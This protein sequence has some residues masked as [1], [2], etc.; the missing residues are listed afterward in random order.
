MSAP[1]RYGGFSQSRTEQLVRGM[2]VVFLLVSTVLVTALVMR[3]ADYVYPIGTCL[4]GNWD[5]EGVDQIEAVQCTEQHDYLV[6]SVA[7]DWNE[8]PPATVSRVQVST[9]GLA[10]RDRYVCLVAA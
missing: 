7:D 4:R 3:P 2:F 5:Y 10:P 6:V 1:D 8:C 9:G